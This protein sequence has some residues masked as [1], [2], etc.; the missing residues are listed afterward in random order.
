MEGLGGGCSCKLRCPH[1]DELMETDALMFLW[2]ERSD[3][4]LLALINNSKHSLCFFVPVLVL[5][6]MTT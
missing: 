5:K 2:M 4:D 3:L 6:S 1:C